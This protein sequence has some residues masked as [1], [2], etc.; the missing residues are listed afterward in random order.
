MFKTDF[1]V[2]FSDVDNAGIFYYPRFF[3]AFHVAFEK[4]WEEEYG[5]GYHEILHD[6]KVGFPAV[7][8]ECNFRKPVTFGE[9]YEIWLG[10]VRI[11]NTSVTFR[12]ELRHRETGEVH[13]ATDTTKAVVDMDRFRARPL[14]ENIRTAFEGLQI[15]KTDG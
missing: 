8:I 1:T 7:H 5:R 2:R 14:P 11:G 12:Y 6:D 4:W 13:A 9:P 10:V 15:E 3:H